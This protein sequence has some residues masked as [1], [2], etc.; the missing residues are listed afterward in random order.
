MPLPEISLFGRTTTRIGLGCGRLIGG[1]SFRTSARLVEAALELGIRHFD[2]APSYG[3]GTAEDVLGA[4]PGG[5]RDVTVTT[6]I[7]APRP[8]N[9]PQRGWVHRQAKFLLDRA[10]GLK[11]LA[12]RMLVRRTARPA[13][14]R[15]DF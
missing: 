14:P 8:A 5:V 1:T 13:K 11:T 15:Y 3:L 7:G 6:K 4:V 2:V 10:G 9:P 12:R